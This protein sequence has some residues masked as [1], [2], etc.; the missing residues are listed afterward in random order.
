MRRGPPTR[1]SPPAV[2][3]IPMLWGN[4]R[5]RPG[6]QTHILRG[7]PPCLPTR[8]PAR[9]VAPPS[10]L[11]RPLADGRS[12]RCPHCGTFFSAS[13][14]PPER[15]RRVSP[16]LILFGVA[17]VAA[18]LLAGGVVTLV[19]LLGRDPRPA[20]R[21]EEQERLA[22][23]L[24]EQKKQLE[25][26]RAKLDED[27]HRLEFEGLLKRGDGA[28]AK[29]QYEEAEEAYGNALKL[30][31]AD[32]DALK[33]LVAAKAALASASTSKEDVEKRRADAARLVKEGR[34]AME[35]K[36]F[37]LAVRSSTAP[38]AVPGR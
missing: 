11:G 9:S 33:G 25:E 14:E 17:A 5:R 13:S 35:A 16:P 29:K 37:A 4:Q 24:A 32:P 8:S 36:Q 23:Q 27:K 2:R 22:L 6:E 20:P 7:N 30:F 38:P 10:E 26:E 15:A 19:L 3:S 18:A 28:L 1:K 12:V 34:A 31:P 21:N